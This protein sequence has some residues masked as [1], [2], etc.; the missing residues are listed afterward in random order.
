M[1]LLRQR[2]FAL[3]LAGLAVNAIGSW[4]SLIAI[5][6]YATYRYHAGPGE[7][8]LLVAGWSGPSAVL[9]A[10]AGTP[11]DHFGPRRVLLAC[12]ALASV[13]AGSMAL[14]GSLS[15]LVVLVMAYGVIRAVALPAA[16]ALPPRVVERGDLL[17]ANAMFG[18][19]EQLAIVIGPLAASVAIGVAGVGAAFWFDAVTYLVGVAVIAPL[20]LTHG[21]DEPMSAAGGG[22][23]GGVWSGLA[24]LWASPRLRIV[25][26]LAA[27]TFV[28][29]GGF[30]VIEPLYVSRVIHR[31]PSQLALFQVAFGIGLV[32]TS[33]LIPR[34]GD[35]AVGIRPL[36]LCVIASS[37]GSILYVGTRSVAV[38]YAGVTLWGISGAFFWAPTVTTLQ[39]GSPVALH[40]RVLGAFRALNGWTH[41]IALPIIGVTA[42]AWGVR[43]A[44]ILI[45]AL[46]IGTGI[47]AVI[48]DARGARA[49]GTGASGGLAAPV[50][51]GSG[52]A[53]AAR[54]GREPGG[55]EGYEPEDEGGRP[56]GHV[57]ARQ[58]GVLSG[59]EPGEILGGGGEVHDRDDDEDDPSDHARDGRWLDDD[60]IGHGAH[61]TGPAAG[62]GGA[63]MIDG[64]PAG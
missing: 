27:A 19:S 29:W 18:V 53:A 28:M 55:G 25:L 1:H 8:A 14:S 4:T 59:E 46:V 33:L 40:G 50:G 17:A 22:I 9:G 36:A 54:V 44:A 10:F 57:V 38:A 6:G 45:G 23:G 62:R 34:L 42:A 32:A 37:S 43:T 13:V 63:P 3:L 16:D 26:A 41:L 15:A 49:P 11:I 60:A 31:P 35:R 52:G 39:R 7:V 64:P 30:A 47:S 5:W 51:G 58:P 21:N 56:V 12:Y 24:A 2:R 48:L 61:V 20:R